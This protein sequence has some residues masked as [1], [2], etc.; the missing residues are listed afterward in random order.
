VAITLNERSNTYK[1]ILEVEELMEKY[2]LKI[3]GSYLTITGPAGVTYNIGRDQSE[4][5]RTI[6]EHF[7]RHE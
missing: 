5:P 6:D 2:G 4:F 1:N 7:W 3:E